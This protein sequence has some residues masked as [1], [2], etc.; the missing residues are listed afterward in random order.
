[1]GWLLI[2]LTPSFKI[3]TGSI[4]PE[5]QSLFGRKGLTSK[6]VPQ[7]GSRITKLLFPPQTPR[8]VMPLLLRPCQSSTSSFLSSLPC[9]P[10]QTLGEENEEKHTSQEAF[11]SLC[12]P[13]R[14]EQTSINSACSPTLLLSSL[15]SFLCVCVC[16][17]FFPSLRLCLQA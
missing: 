1:M 17:V 14:P 12:F 16:V 2:L 6:W 5:S 10:L 15:L 9:L 3:P 11:P 4:A 8:G 7:E 13:A